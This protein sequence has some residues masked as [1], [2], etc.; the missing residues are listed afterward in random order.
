M[1]Y[2]CFVAFVIV[3]FAGRVGPALGETCAIEKLETPNFQQRF[4][5]HH[6]DLIVLLDVDKEYQQYLQDIRSGKTVPGMTANQTFRELAKPLTKAKEQRLEGTRFR[7][8]SNLELGPD[9]VIQV[10]DWP[11][12]CELAS[13][14]HV[15]TIWLDLPVGLSY[16]L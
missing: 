1:L 3:A 14:P 8:H 6:Y 7:I 2:R 16:A 5:E 9:V 12:V 11:D 13:N 15:V 10:A 4:L